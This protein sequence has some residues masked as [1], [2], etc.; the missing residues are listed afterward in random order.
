MDQYIHI[1]NITGPYHTIQNTTNGEIQH[2]QTFRPL[3]FNYDLL[4]KKSGNHLT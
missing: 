4:G 2:Q 3:G 1:Q